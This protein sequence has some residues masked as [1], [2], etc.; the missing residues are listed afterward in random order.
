[1]SSVQFLQGR[2]RTLDPDS[3]FQGVEITFFGDPDSLILTWQS[4][5]YLNHNGQRHEDVEKKR[6]YSYIII[7]P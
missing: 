5:M 1:M 7:F 4:S 2:I 6:E 3:S